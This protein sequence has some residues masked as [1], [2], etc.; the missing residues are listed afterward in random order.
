ML[1]IIDANIAKWQN[2]G[3]R[4]ERKLFTTFWQKIYCLDG[5]RPVLF[6][7]HPKAAYD[8]CKTQRNCMTL[9]DN[10]LYM[11]PQAALFQH[12]YNNGY[13]GEEWKLAADYK[14]L[15]STATWREVADF[16]NNKYE[17]AICGMCPSR[18]IK[19]TPSEKA[20]IQGLKDK[21]LL[22]ILQ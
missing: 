11:C 17:Q 9:L 5:A 4:V 7:S 18:W 20:N 22:A 15:P 8:R 1:E 14:P 19:A 6:N 3:L 2:A 10:H 16:V 12:A 21:K 13:I